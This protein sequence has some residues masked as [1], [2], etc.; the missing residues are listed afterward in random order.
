M[1]WSKKAKRRGLI[2]P[3]AIS[4]LG[5]RIVQAAIA[6]GDTETA[7]RALELIARMCGEWIPGRPGP[8]SRSTA[9]KPATTSQ[10]E[11]G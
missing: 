1:P 9:R 8:G 4:V 5:S 7:Q 3:P 11:D 6:K 10:A 2:G